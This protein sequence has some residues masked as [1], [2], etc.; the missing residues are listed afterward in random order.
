MSEASYNKIKMV[1]GIDALEKAYG[2]LND[3]LS[4]LQTDLGRNLS[5]WTG[6][7]QEAY[8]GV[9]RDWDESAKRMASIIN[10][11]GTVMSS[12]NDTT[13]QNESKVESS[14]A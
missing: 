1:Q 8:H 3:R 5:H 6:A 7:A 12:I 4:N 11:M 9:Q 14:W 2:D 10:K 13:W